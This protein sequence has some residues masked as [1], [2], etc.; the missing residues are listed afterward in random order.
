MYDRAIG[1]SAGHLYVADLDKTP[2]SLCNTLI[3][4]YAQKHSITSNAAIDIIG[5]LMDKIIS[6]A[7]QPS[8]AQQQELLQSSSTP[9]GENNFPMS[10]SASSGGTLGAS[11]GGTLG[12]SS[13]DASAN[14]RGASMSNRG[15]R[16]RMTGTELVFY[17]LDGCPH[18]IAVE[19]EWAKAK[20]KERTTGERLKLIEIE[21][22]DLNPDEQKQIRSFPTFVFKRDGK[23]L[24]TFDG[25]DRTA[26][27]LLAWGKAHLAKPG[28]RQRRKASGRRS[29]NKRK[30]G[31]RR[32]RPRKH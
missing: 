9:I 27:T 19:P 16:A 22:S 6:G 11:S 23:L 18:C 26:A 15:A 17:R 31:T 1:A 21:A 3:T 7:I 5:A 8:D 30:H 14:S 13:G 32:L 29:S 12:A 4:S 24:D 25:G 28:G 20:A 10:A 2:P